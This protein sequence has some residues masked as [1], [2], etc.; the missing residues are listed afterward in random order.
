MRIF[1]N[2]AAAR[3]CYTDYKTKIDTLLAKIEKRGQIKALEHPSSSSLT[4]QGSSKRNFA[5]SVPP[6]PKPVK[7]RE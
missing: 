1:D 7:P 2:D 4:S 3:A 5:G 6:P